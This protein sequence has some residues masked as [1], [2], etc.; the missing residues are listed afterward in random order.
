MRGSDDSADAAASAAFAAACSRRGAELAQRAAARPGDALPFASLRETI[1][2]FG[3][4][5]ASLARVRSNVV[6]PLEPARA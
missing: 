5:V 1:G 2:S 4:G 3:G 6:S